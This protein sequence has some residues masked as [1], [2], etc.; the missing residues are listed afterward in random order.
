MHRLDPKDVHL[1]TRA[2]CLLEKMSTDGKRKTSYYKHVFF[3]L[4]GYFSV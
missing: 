1:Q 3:S 4:R 2:G